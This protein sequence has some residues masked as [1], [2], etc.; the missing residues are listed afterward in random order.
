MPTELQVHAVR[1]AGM[2][3]T[4]TAG[5]H[6]VTLDYPMQ[7][8]ETGAG[9]TPLQMLLASLCV[10]GGS[11]VGLVLER[12]KQP[13]AGLEVDARGVRSDEHPTVL[14]EIEL[15]F[16]VRGPGVQPEV[17]QRA[18]TIAETQLCPVWAMLKAGTPITASYRL[19]AD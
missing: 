9:P 18:L 8:G 16:T 3:F 14:T 5:A 19:V 10:C 12:M 7:P 6:S 11:T 1:E 17:V 13:F 2:R 4:A 15:V